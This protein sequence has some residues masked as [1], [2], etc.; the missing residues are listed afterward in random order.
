MIFIWSSIPLF[1]TDLIKIGHF[2][3]L[4]SKVQGSGFR[5]PEL[6]ASRLFPICLCVAPVCAC[7]CVARR[8]VQRTGRRRQVPLISLGK[9]P[10]SVNLWTLNLWTSE[11]WTSEPLNLWTRPIHH[12]ADYDNIIFYIPAILMCIPAQSMGTRKNCKRFSVFFVGS[13]VKTGFYHQ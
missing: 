6:I 9:H 13:V 8:Q 2:V 7:L 1:I 3:G 10:E 5:V 12:F 11:P 4:G